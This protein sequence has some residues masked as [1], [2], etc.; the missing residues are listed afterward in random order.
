MDANAKEAK[1]TNEIMDIEVFLLINTKDLREMGLSVGGKERNWA[2][3]G[4]KNFTIAGLR[5]SC[6]FQFTTIW[7]CC[8]KQSKYVYNN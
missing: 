3:T 8:Y 2:I 6:R 1:R 5:C 7:I 4:V